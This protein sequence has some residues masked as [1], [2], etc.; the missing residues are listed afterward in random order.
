[1]YGGDRFVHISRSN[2]AQHVNGFV[3]GDHRII[4]RV[5]NRDLV[6][7]KI[8]DTARLERRNKVVTLQRGLV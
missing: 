8:I 2:Q 6:K 5:V 3:V 1:M 7:I 4:I